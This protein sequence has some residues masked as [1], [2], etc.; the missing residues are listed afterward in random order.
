[1]SNP[2]PLFSVKVSSISCIFSR[3][4]FNFNFTREMMKTKLFDG[5]TLKS[6]LGLI[7]WCSSL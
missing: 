3:H 5:L 4:D 6:N 2:N 1:M 7:Q